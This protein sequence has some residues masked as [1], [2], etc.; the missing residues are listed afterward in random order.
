MR[1][2]CG[3][4]CKAPGTALNKKQTKLTSILITT[5]VK[6][7]VPTATKT[8]KSFRDTFKQKRFIMRISF[9]LSCKH[10][11]QEFCEMW[12]GIPQV[13]TNYARQPGEDVAG[14]P[15][16]N[17]TPPVPSPPQRPPQDTGHR[18]QS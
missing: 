7:Y 9:S 17:T 14:C 4:A 8:E 10:S 12:G 5:T 16:K 18:V 15:P 6:M 1:I 11:L 13:Y 3:N 2:K